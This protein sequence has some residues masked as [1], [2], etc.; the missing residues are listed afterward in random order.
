MQTI[1]ILNQRLSDMKKTLQH[2]L[3]SSSTEKIGAVTVSNANASKVNG[4]AI[5]N[6]EAETDQLVNNNSKKAT[7]VVMDDVNLKYLKHVILKFLT[8]R[9][10]CHYVLFF[11]FLSVN[12]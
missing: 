3:K 6:N 4:N 7:P 5:G 9:E 10:V 8:S 12:F 1:K 11:C 2:E